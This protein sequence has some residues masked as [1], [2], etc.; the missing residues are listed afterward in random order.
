MA[1]KPAT[2]W[3]PTQ[4]SSLPGHWWS[5]IQ[6]GKHTGDGPHFQ[7]CRCHFGLCIVVQR[8]RLLVQL[9]TGVVVVLRRVER[10]GE[11]DLLREATHLCIGEAG[12]ELPAR[13]QGSRRSSV[14]YQQWG[15]ISGRGEVCQAEISQ[16]L[17]HLA[18]ITCTTA[19]AC[20][21][22]AAGGVA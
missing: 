18:T 8:L 5:N 13:G 12:S 14:N 11:N 9:R 7:C 10:V 6:G 4:A 3:D 2:K 1:Q 20:E 15:G 17:L 22:V 16:G 19:A 21:T